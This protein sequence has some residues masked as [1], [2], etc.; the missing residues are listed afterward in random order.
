M[1]QPGAGDERYATPAY[2]DA[3]SEVFNVKGFLR[4]AAVTS[5]IGAWDNYYAT[6]ANYFVYNSGRRGVSG[7]D[8]MSK[9]Y[10]TWLP[11]DYDNSF[12]TAS[13]GE[14]GTK[15]ASSTGSATTG[16]ATWSRS[17]SWEIF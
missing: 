9:P 8:V 14:R 1:G 17:H 6:P 12:G 4:W 3:L 11:W 2:R 10:F 5:L 7:A 13:S 16:R 15:R